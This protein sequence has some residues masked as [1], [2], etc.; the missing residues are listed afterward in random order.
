MSDE[1]LRDAIHRL[2]SHYPKYGYRHITK[3]LVRLGYAVGYRR[4]ARL[5]KAD[6]L[7]VAVKRAGFRTTQSLE[8]R[9]QWSNRID[10]LDI[11]RCDQVWVG[12]I[13]YVRLKGHCVYVA[14]LMDVFTCMIKEWQASRYL[15]QPLS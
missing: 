6:N 9:H 12:D 11:T 3:L 1:V 7:T 14:V 5:M 2:A 13:T 15:N 4:V 10:N 8:G